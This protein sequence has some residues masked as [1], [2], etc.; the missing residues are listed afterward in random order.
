M[1]NYLQAFATTFDLEKHITFNTQ[2]VRA[3]PLFR[4][5]LPSNG[6]NGS[7]AP[8]EPPTDLKEAAE[9]AQGIMPWPRWRLTT[10]PTSVSHHPACT[11]L[12]WRFAVCTAQVPPPCWTLNVLSQLL[13]LQCRS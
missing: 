9:Q 5:A 7:S 2:V 6:S 10:I 1:L 12:G 4:A 11:S 13:L 8:A 3:Q